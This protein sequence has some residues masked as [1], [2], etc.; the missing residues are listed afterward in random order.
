MVKELDLNTY[1]D[2]ISGK[3]LA[4]VDFYATWCMPCKMLAPILDKVSDSFTD[5]RFARLDIDQAVA[6]ATKLN[7][8]SVPSLYVFKDGA[9][10]KLLVG[11]LNENQLREALTTL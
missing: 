7:I 10:Y 5:I 8:S 2:F 6:L 9:P 1:N 11:Y 4:L 3:G